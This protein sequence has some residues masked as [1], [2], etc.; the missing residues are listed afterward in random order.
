MRSIGFRACWKRWSDFD[1]KPSRGKAAIG[2]RHPNGGFTLLEVVLA[3][4]IATGMLAVVF[5]FYHQAAELRTQVLREITRVT[6]A[7]L[8][9][10]RLTSELRTA[11]P[12]T[13]LRSG[14]WGSSNQLEFVRLV[15]P[16]TSSPGATTNEVALPLSPTLKKIQYRLNS[17]P[18]ETNS[19]VLL[20]LEEPLISAPESTVTNETT[21]VA[22]LEPA[23]RGLLLTREFQFVSFRFWNGTA[24]QDSWSADSLPLGIEVKLGVE[25]LPPETMP[26]DYPYDQF[27]RIISLPLA[28]P[29]P[30]SQD[31]S[32]P[33][34]TPAGT[35][36]EGRAAL[37]RRNPRSV[38]RA[39]ESAPSSIDT[40]NRPLPGAAPVHRREEPA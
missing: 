38:G 16:V 10:E 40:M 15:A 5:Y 37:H 14:L 35:S 25:S 39:T 6:A 4:V 24:W 34:E 33:E 2:R 22:E 32:A 9:L 26:E 29:A 11:L 18:D 27:S 19:A 3:V 13:D 21:T 36:P 28:V 30:P 12:G 1:D 23:P 31:E 20:R 7:R 17:S 8:I